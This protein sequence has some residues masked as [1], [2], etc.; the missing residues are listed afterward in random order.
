MDDC[1]LTRS[2][3]CASFI[4]Q[5]VV[6]VPWKQ[7]LLS[8]VPEETKPAYLYHF[9]SLLARIV[10]YPSCYT[11][12]TASFL[13]LLKNMSQRQDWNAILLEHCEAL[14]KT[15]AGLLPGECLTSPTEAIAVYQMSVLPFY[16]PIKDHYSIWRKICCFSPKEPYS[17]VSLLKQTVWLRTEC[18]LLLKGSVN[19]TAVA[20][21]SMI[22]DVHALASNHGRWSSR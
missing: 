7:V 3:D 1:L 6:R 18:Q 2:K 12:V 15:V 21:T 9:A 22:S 19:D 4:T 13:D 10:S 14:S 11:K 16:S 20:Y 8:H 5:M 17:S